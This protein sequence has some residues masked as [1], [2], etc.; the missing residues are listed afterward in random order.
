MLNLQ[1]EKPREKFYNV[2]F[3]ALLDIFQKQK[4][5]QNNKTHLPNL[6]ISYIVDTE[7]QKMINR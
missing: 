7:E 3:S 1:R 6:N 4:N 5:S 2:L